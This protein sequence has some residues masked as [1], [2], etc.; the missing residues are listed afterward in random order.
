MMLRIAPSNYV[1]TNTNIPA[2]FLEK[3]L[4]RQVF[5]VWNGKQW[6]FFPEYTFLPHA[7]KR[8]MP[9][10]YNIRFKSK[11]KSNTSA[12]VGGKCRFLGKG[13]KYVYQK[14]LVNMKER[15]FFHVIIVRA[16]KH[17]CYF[18]SSHTLFYDWIFIYQ[19]KKAVLCCKHI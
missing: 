18:H 6:V 2:Y 12:S 11:G 15:L 19:R 3:V 10:V 13:K 14:K 8:N 16:E 9:S 7:N 1:Q 4:Q 5:Y 17:S